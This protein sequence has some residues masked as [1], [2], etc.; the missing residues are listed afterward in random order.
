MIVRLVLVVYGLP[1]V[2]GSG[3]HGAGKHHG[4]GARQHK[5][6]EAANPILST[7]H[8]LGFKCTA[9]V[10][11]TGGECIL[12]TLSSA[13]PLSALSRCELQQRHSEQEC[14]EICARSPDCNHVTIDRVGRRCIA[15]T[16]V[17]GTT[18][19]F[20]HKREDKSWISCA[21][22]NS[23]WTRP[24]TLS[25]AKSSRFECVPENSYSGVLRYIGNTTLQACKHTC[26]G[27]P[28]CGA[29][30][31]KQDG[32][33][34]LKETP[35]VTLSQGPD[36]HG[37]VTCALQEPVAQTPPGSSR[38]M[39]GLTADGENDVPAR[40][41]EPSIDV[42][43]AHRAEPLHWVGEE[44]QRAPQQTRFL[45]YQHVDT[46]ETVSRPAGLP[47]SAAVVRIPNRGLE[48]ASFLQHIVSNYDSLADWTCFTQADRPT[49]G[50]GGLHEGGGH[51][52][53]GVKFGDYLVVRPSGSFFMYTGAV[54]LPGLGQSSRSAYTQST[55]VFERRTSHSACPSKNH[56]CAT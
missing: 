3:R 27:A 56:W 45:V 7:A 47:R 25:T 48:A 44:L 17:R 22:R 35:A 50:Y 49:F 26:L 23:H 52:M 8:G 33:C 6:V 14:L 32:R 4:R 38:R 53:K 18:R 34:W 20:R 16:R 29:L 43:V 13:S 46:E 15:Y 1:L 28:G 40:A 31:H 51:M 36:S 37:T 24:P 12:S 2:A 54:V 10:I 30:V 9:G 19:L 5:R 42:V 21:R 39:R 55:A 11:A 41:S